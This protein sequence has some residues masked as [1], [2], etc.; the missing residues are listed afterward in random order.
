MT[1]HLYRLVGA[2][3]AAAVAAVTLVTPAAAA[4]GSFADTSARIGSQLSGQVAKQSQAEASRGR[5]DRRDQRTHGTQAA[6]YPWAAVAPG[7]NNQ[8]PSEPPPSEPP[9]SEPPP[10]EP[11]PSEPPPVVSPPSVDGVLFGGTAQRRAGET[12]AQA[13]S[14][15][16]ATY[17]G[18]DVIRVFHSGVPSS[19][20][21]I[22]ADVGQTP[23]VVSFK[24]SPADV[25]NGRYD[26]L[27]RGWFAAAPT[28]R[29]TWWTYW[30]EPE[31]DIEAGRFTAAQYRAAWAHLADLAQTAG[32]RQLRA[33]LILMCW[34]LERASG[35]TWTDYYAAGDIQAQGWDCYNSAGR[36]GS[37]RSAASILEDVTAV[38]AKTGLPWGLTEFGSLLV[39]GDDGT[40][41]AAWLSDMA[42]VATAGGGQFLT[43]F[44]S[45]IGVEYRLLDDPSRNRWRTLIAG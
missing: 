18:M 26:D 27:M 44:D 30:H 43:Y 22:T 17:G 42:A 7:N 9:P 36:S 16:K 5:H 15:V 6:E 8:P 10:S 29:P 38:A 1:A 32:N 31:D 4:I 2:T 40:G 28:D 39:A 21:K 24:M 41:R 23:V 3:A 13:V 14:R 37:Y 12:F 11:P 25:V 19:W 35:R 45:N 20:A 33:T 34:S